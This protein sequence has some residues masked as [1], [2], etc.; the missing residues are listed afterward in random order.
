MSVSLFPVT[1][2]PHGAITPT[3]RNPGQL[4]LQARLWVQ[5]DKNLFLL[6]LAGQCSVFCILVPELRVPMVCAGPAVAEVLGREPGIHG[7]EAEETPLAP[8]VCRTLM[9][10][11]KIIVLVEPQNIGLVP[12]CKINVKEVG[13]DLSWCDFGC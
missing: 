4:W 2:W 1:E 9:P 7:V 10:T 3:V 8:L 5:P 11:R 12:E 13:G 6:D